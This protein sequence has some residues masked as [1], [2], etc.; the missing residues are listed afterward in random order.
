MTPVT[1]LPPS[2]GVFSLSQ[3]PLLPNSI[4]PSSYTSGP[5][6]TL[7]KTHGPIILMPQSS[8]TLHTLA[9][10]RILPGILFAGFSTVCPRRPHL[11]ARL[12]SVLILFFLLV[13]GIAIMVF[14][15]C[16]TGLFDPEHR[17]GQ[18]V[19]WG[20]VSYT[21]V[22]FSILT[23]LTAMS[24]VTLSISFI[25]NRQFTG[26]EGVV[27][28]GPFGYVLFISPMAISFLTNA[29]AIL[30]NWLA[31]GL[32]VSSLFDHAL[33]HPCVSPQLLSQLYRCYVIYS[34]NLW[35]IVFPC[36]IYL[37]SVGVHPSSPRTGGGI[38]G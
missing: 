3:S 38:H 12:I 36:L 14:F 1:S 23:A 35:V 19:K 22:M 28:P 30:N 11:R 24:S 9:R 10:R 27:P 37:G 26:V 31:D 18:R 25:D 33:T 34:M 32:L 29:M 6:P 17:R 21:M 20:L 2:S 7:S 4:P 16:I 13:P 8:R 5:C 15:R